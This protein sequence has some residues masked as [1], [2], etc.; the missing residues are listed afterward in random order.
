MRTLNWKS[1]VMWTAPSLLFLLVALVGGPAP[2]F[3]GPDVVLYEVTENMKLTKN[4]RMNQHRVATSA[5]IGFAEPGTPLCPGAT[6]CTINAIGNDNVSLT[7]GKGPVFG[8]FTVVINEPGSVDSPEF[9]VMKGRFRG[10][11]DFTPAFQGASFGTAEGR[12]TI[13][14]VHG[15]FPFTGFFRQPFIGTDPAPVQPF[16]GA[17]QRQF[18]CGFRSSPSPIPGHGDVAWTQTYNGPFDNGNTCIN[19]TA[20][21]LA[22]GFPTV[23]FEIT[24]D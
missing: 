6:R 2:A 8:T 14:D 1:T 21:E 4:H 23:R 16:P 20:D 22:I 5:L 17:T 12:M 13:D 19:A 24:F 9:V 11:I 18:H 10:T 15:K 7:T 3:A